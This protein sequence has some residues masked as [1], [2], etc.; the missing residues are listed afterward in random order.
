V[1]VYKGTLVESLNEEREEIKKR[2]ILSLVVY[3]VIYF[4]VWVSVVIVRIIQATGN[5][6]P[7]EYYDIAS[8]IV[9]FTGFFDGAWFGFSRDIFTNASLWCCKNSASTN[10]EEGPRE[11]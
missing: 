11:L 7:A 10:V 3:P 2:R 6:V 1:Y 8:I 5:D 9:P 4:V